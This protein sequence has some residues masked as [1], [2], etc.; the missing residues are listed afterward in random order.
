MY[1]V[2]VNTITSDWIPIL[3]FETDFDFVFLLL[4]LDKSDILYGCKTRQKKT[5]NSRIKLIFFCFAMSDWKHLVIFPFVF[6]TFHSRQT[7][8]FVYLNK[9]WK[10]YCFL[11][12]NTLIAN[13]ELSSY[14]KYLLIW[15]YN[16]KSSFTMKQNLIT[17]QETGDKYQYLPANHFRINQKLISRKKKPFLLAKSELVRQKYFG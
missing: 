2:Q 1:L 8:V 10:I 6:I 5:S 11:V 14:L 9:T 12:S 17:Y 13:Y 4:F 15:T 7:S 16:L 3:S